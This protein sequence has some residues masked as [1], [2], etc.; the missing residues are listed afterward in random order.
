MEPPQYNGGLSGL[1]KR[2]YLAKIKPWKR[3]REA[4]DLIFKP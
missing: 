1:Q 3:I 4:L 2:E